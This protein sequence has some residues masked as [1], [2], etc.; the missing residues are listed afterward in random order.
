MKSALSLRGLTQKQIWLVIALAGVAMVTAASQRAS[1]LRAVGWVLVASDTMERVDIIII[2]QDAGGAGV[3]EASDL[4]QKGAADRV[5]VFTDPPDREDLEFLRRGLPYEN[6]AA[7][8]IRQLG[9]LGVR[10]VV[11]INTDEAGSEASAQSLPIW[12]KQHQVHSFVFVAAKD[13]SLRLRRLLNRMLSGTQI[14]ALV[15]PEHYSVFDPDRWLETRAGTRRL[16]V[17][18]QKV[19]LDFLLHPFS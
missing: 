2:A 19:L 5:A 11:Q 16:I 6:A 8:Q 7:I 17:A 4:V 13:H 12:C 14:R 3:F 9:W 1:I 15:Q 10:N 18:M